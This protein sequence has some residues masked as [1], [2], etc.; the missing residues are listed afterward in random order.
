[1]WSLN[2][3]TALEEEEAIYERFLKRE[4]RRKRKRRK[5]LRSRNTSLLNIRYYKIRRNGCYS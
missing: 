3:E 5:P 4:R 2:L 1:M